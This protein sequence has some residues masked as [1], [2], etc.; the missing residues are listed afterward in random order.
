MTKQ[1]YI[2]RAIE[3]A[4]KIVEHNYTT[5]ETS[6][7]YNIKKKELWYILHKIVSKQDPKLYAEVLRVFDENKTK[8]IVTARQQKEKERQFI[9]KFTN[10]ILGV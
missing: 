9:E 10:I 6:N 4:R 5:R 1:E 7:L 2:K 3:I 8:A